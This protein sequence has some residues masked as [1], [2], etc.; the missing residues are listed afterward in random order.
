L[1]VWLGLFSAV[2]GLEGL[3]C[4]DRWVE[5]GFGREAGRVALLA[6]WTSAIAL[7]LLLLFGL[8]SRRFASPSVFGQG[9][10]LALAGAALLATV[11]TLLP[12][13]MN[14]LCL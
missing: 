6:A 13:A 2:Y 5:M 12:V 4:S 1:T 10:S 11:W 3:V 9:I 7:Q 8:R 14:S